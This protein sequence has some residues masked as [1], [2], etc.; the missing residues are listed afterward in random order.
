MQRHLVP[1]RLLGV[2]IVILLPPYEVHKLTLTLVVSH[3]Q[4]KGSERSRRLFRRA[5]TVV[6]A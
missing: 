1:V 2:T 5:D 4:K 3:F 6:V